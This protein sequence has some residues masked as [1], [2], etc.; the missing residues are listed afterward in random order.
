MSDPKIVSAYLYK[1]PSPHG[2][3]VVVASFDDGRKDVAVVP[4][5]SFEIKWTDAGQFV[6]KTAAQVCKMKDEYLGC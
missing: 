4:F 1:Y 5:D 2:D 6:G 3:T